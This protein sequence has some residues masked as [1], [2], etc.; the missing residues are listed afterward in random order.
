M[1]KWIIRYSL[2]L[3]AF[4]IIASHVTTLF[5]GSI[6]YCII[7]AGAQE[8][9]NDNEPDVDKEKIISTSIVSLF[10]TRYQINNYPDNDS[11]IFSSILDTEIN[12]PESTFL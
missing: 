1:K 7:K 9:E 8:K 5:T 4:S 12:P 11:K 10:F 6:E 2:F 3:V